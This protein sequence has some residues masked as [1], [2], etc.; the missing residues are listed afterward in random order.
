MINQPPSLADRR[1]DLG[2][3]HWL[4]FMAWAPNVELNPQWAHLA[5][6]MR[7]HPVV[8]ATVGHRCGPMKVPDERVVHFR[9]PLTDAVH[10]FRSLERWEVECWDPLTL[11]ES[12]DAG[13]V[14]GD[15]G[16]IRSGRWLPR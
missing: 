6:L 15:H 12:L 16:A 3:D 5:V 13:C 4:R 2:R 14:C 11:S 9:T 10:S 7:E 8:G 1:L